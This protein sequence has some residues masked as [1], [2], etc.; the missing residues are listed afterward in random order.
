M[1]PSQRLHTPFHESN[2][3]SSRPTHALLTALS[4]LIH[5]PQELYLNS[6]TI[7]DRG[8]TALAEAVSKGAMADS[9]RICLGRNPVSAD[10]MQTLKETAAEQRGIRV[11]F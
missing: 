9:G 11:D 5:D 7:G 10:A 2:S 6:N 1:A 3:R 4:R 8:C